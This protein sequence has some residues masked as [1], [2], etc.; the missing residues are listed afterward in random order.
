MKALYIGK[1]QPFHT[2]HKKVFD[3]AKTLFGEVII[4]L[5]SPKMSGFFSMDERVKMIRQN[6]GVDP[7]VLE[8]LEPEHGLY[9]DWGRYALSVTGPI[10]IL[11][12]GNN[13]VRDD[14]LNNNIPIL[15]VPRYGEVRGSA[16]RAAITRKDNSWRDLVTL[17]TKEIIEQSDFYRR[18]LGHG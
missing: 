15:L 7:L 16:I 4:A 9:N 8:D 18:H 3:L 2:G 1:F 13:M 6:T 5:G 10:D 14:F 17:A 11:V 12:T